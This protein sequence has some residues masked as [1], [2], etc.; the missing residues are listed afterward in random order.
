METEKKP[1]VKQ[2][3]VYLLEH[4][5]DVIKKLASLNRESL[6]KWIESAIDLKIKKEDK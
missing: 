4:K 3:P 2:V 6:T 1:I 5:Y